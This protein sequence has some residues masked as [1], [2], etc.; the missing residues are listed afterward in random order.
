M[1]IH[2]RRVPSWRALCKSFLVPRAASRKA[3]PPS[4]HSRGSI[5]PG[6]AALPALT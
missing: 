5:L 3:L 1:I 6:A 2:V 4:R